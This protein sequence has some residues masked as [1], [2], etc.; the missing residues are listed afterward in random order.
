MINQVK[1]HGFVECET[2]LASF[3]SVFEARV[4]LFHVDQV[5]IDL[6]KLNEA[7]MNFNI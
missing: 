3:L 5:L 1:L 2:S 4:L 7:I 6:W